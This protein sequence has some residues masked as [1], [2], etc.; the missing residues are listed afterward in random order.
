MPETKN[1]RSLFSCILIPPFISLLIYLVNKSTW[2]LNEIWLEANKWIDPLKHYY[3]IYLLGSKKFVIYRWLMIFEMS[4]SAE[5]HCKKLV[6]YFLCLFYIKYVFISDY[7]RKFSL[8]AELEILQQLRAPSMVRILI[9]FS[10]F[11]RNR[12]RLQILVGSG[13]VLNITYWNINYM[14]FYAKMK[15]WLIR[16]HPVRFFSGL[17]SGCLVSR[18]LLWIRMCMCPWISFGSG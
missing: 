17:G 7:K 16:N 10:N 15:S 4:Y 14:D 11:G 1:Q 3:T 8:E 5:L 13:S 18:R 9:R 6:L 2:H 12:M